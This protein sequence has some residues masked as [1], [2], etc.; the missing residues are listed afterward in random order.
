MHGW[1]VY[2]FQ[3][4]TIYLRAQV[5]VGARRRLSKAKH[6]VFA[7]TLTNSEFLRLSQSV[8]TKVSTTVRNELMHIVTLWL[9]T[10]C[11]ESKYNQKLIFS[12]HKWGPKN[13]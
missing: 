11:V 5:L 4:H 2:I 13:V 3:I 8:C 6:K 12:R 10:W 7:M 1:A 9:F